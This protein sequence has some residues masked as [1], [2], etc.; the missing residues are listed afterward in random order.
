MTRSPP[1]YKNKHCHRCGMD[2][3]E[4]VRDLKDDL[5]HLLAYLEECGVQHVEVVGKECIEAKLRERRPED[6]IDV[7]LLVKCMEVTLN[8]QRSAS[9]EVGPDGGVHFKVTTAAEYLLH[10]DFEKENEELEQ[11][12]WKVVAREARKRAYWGDVA[13]AR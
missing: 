3:A 5:L 6:H 9:R 1:I 2:P 13:C 11:V 7:K 12:Y 4:P 8:E 10:P